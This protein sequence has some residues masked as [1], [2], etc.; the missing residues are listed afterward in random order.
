MHIVQIITILL[1]TNLDGVKMDH[2]RLNIFHNYGPGKTLR[3][4]MMSLEMH[5]WVGAAERSKGDGGKLHMWNEKPSS[6]G[7]S[8]VGERE[9]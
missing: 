2:V 6:E 5:K 3:P 4:A 9:R 8:D 1:I 7:W